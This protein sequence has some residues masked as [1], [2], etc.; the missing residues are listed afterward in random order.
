MTLSAA[1]NGCHLPALAVTPRAPAPYVI[2]GYDPGSMHGF[3]AVVKQHPPS[4]SLKFVP[5][6]APTALLVQVAVLNQITEVLLQRISAHTRQS[7]RVANRDAP[8]LAG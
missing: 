4:P 5:N 2:P 8:M 1:T 7:D 6:P 3:S